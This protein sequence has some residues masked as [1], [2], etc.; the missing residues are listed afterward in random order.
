MTQ[1][2]KQNKIELAFMRL[3]L[4][5]LKTAMIFVT[6]CLIGCAD[7]AF[8]QYVA[9]RQA[10]VATMPNGEA[11]YFAQMQLDQQ[12]LAEKQLQQQ[13]AANVMMAIGAG[14]TA[15][16]ANHRNNVYIYNR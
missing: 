11:R 3:L 14:I 4:A 7:P 9:S 2:T 13:Q 16:S 8:Q 1:K 10:A 5:V 15:A 6:M 12:I